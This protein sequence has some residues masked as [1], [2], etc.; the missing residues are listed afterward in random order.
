MR[1]GKK[2]L[3]ISSFSLSGRRVIVPAR[4]SSTETHLYFTCWFSAYTR[5]DSFVLSPSYLICMYALFISPLSALTIENKLT[6]LGFIFV[7][8]KPE[9]KTWRRSAEVRAY[10]RAVNPLQWPYRPLSFSPFHSSPSLLSLSHHFSISRLKILSTPPPPFSLTPF[11]WMPLQLEW[12][13]H[14]LFG[15]RL[16]Y[17]QP[18]PRFMLRHVGCLLASIYFNYV[19]IARRPLFKCLLIISIRLDMKNWLWT[20]IFS[21][22][23][24]DDRFLSLGFHCIRSGDKRKT[25]VWNVC[26]SFFITWWTFCLVARTI[27]C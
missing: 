8:S 23:L 21:I 9:E 22:I 24:T 11:H 14:K 12:G 25:D 4:C 18:A 10:S 26:R 15:L 5:T 13:R 16:T 2:V 6:F 17:I 1:V 20:V 3:Q 19:L 7:P 27:Y